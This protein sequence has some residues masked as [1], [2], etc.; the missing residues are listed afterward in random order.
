MLSIKNLHVSFATPQ[1]PRCI[2]KGFSLTVEQGAHVSILGHNGS[3]KSTLLRTIAG[4]NTT[5][6][7]SITINGTRV[8]AQP[9]H[10]RAHIIGYAQQNTLLGTA[11]LCSVEENLCF[12]IS[13]TP[14]SLARSRTHLEQAHN[15]LKNSALN[16]YKHRATPAKRLSGGQRQLLAFLMIIQ[17]QTPLLLLDEITA[18]LD[19]QNSENVANTTYQAIKD[20]GR[21][22]LSVTHNLRHA[23]AYSTRLIILAEGDISHDISTADIKKLDELELSK[24]LL[25]STHTTQRH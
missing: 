7:G 13:G 17:K 21:T 11:P 9:A 6:S 1:G 22:S 5:R 25:Q 16:L 23:L 10:K 4:Y 12:A 24:I 14:L 18:A 2:L 3:G 15:I 19:P 8:E 20:S